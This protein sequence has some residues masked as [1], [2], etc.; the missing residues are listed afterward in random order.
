MPSR[1]HASEPRGVRGMG[2]R[3]GSE[4]VFR[5]AGITLRAAIPSMLGMAIKRRWRLRSKGFEGEPSF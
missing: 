2:P 3:H 5:H 4:A 1:T